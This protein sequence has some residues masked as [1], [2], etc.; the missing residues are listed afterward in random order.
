M[1][2]LFTPSETESFS[3]STWTVFCTLEGEPSAG[4]WTRI[5]LEA[6]EKRKEVSH[7]NKHF[8]ELK[9]RKPKR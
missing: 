8:Y 6:E 9:G 4:L 5:D 2:R 1:G 3:S 7:S